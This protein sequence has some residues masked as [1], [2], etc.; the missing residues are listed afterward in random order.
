MTNYNWNS[1]NV[2]ELGIGVSCCPQPTEEDLATVWDRVRPGFVGLINS[3]QGIH[4]FVSNIDGREAMVSIE[5]L[6]HLT[7]SIDEYGHLWHLLNNGTYTVTVEVVGFVPMTKI[8]RV[9]TSEFTEVNFSLPYPSGIPRAIAVL[10]FSSVILCI[11]LC[12]L[13]IHCRQQKIKAVRSYDGFQ[14]LSREERN[15]FEDEEDEEET[16]MFDKGVEQY[17]SNVPSTKVYRDFTSSEEE[18]ESFLKVSSGGRSH[19]AKSEMML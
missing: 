8:V 17:G 6:S 11:M 18:E 16:E 4:I 7:M 3:L 13:L 12:S 10:I 15:I 9:L 5:E 14:L 1:H 19:N 2:I